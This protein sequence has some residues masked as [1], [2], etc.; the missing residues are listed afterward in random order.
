LSSFQSTSF[1]TRDRRAS[2]TAGFT[3]LEV[4]VALAACGAIIAAI[5]PAFSANARN[6]RLAESRIALAAA[7][8]SLLDILPARDKLTDGVARGVIN[9]VDWRMRVTSLPHEVEEGQAPVPWIAY[10]IV[11]DFSTRDGMTSRI[12]TVRLGREVV[13]R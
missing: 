7:E 12:E 8:R 9:G 2:S 6:A 13:T 10:S 4:L 5:A 3:L 11:V 1:N